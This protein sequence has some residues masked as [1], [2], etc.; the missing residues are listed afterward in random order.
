MPL[1]YKTTE[2]KE[3]GQISE[4]TYVGGYLLTDWNRQNFTA[5]AAFFSLQTSAKIQ[6]MCFVLGLLKNTHERKHNFPSQ[7]IALEV[8][9]KDICIR[10]LICN[11]SIFGSHFPEKSG[12][13]FEAASSQVI[14]LMW[15]IGGKHS[16]RSWRRQSLHPMH[17][18]SGSKCLWIPVS[19]HSILSTALLACGACYWKWLSVSWAVQRISHHI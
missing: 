8:S 15:K 10:L 1:K 3:E 12:S 4:L 18:S 13:F 11:V 7:P 9:I 2:D 6:A 5:S 14:F 16:C 17:E 19:L